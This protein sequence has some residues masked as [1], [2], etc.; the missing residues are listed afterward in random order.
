LV[1]AILASPLAFGSPAGATQLV[2]LDFDTETSGGEHFYLEAERDAIQ[3]RLEADYALF[4]Y[5][6]TQTAPS[7]GDFSTLFFNKGASGGLADAIDFRNLDPNDTASFNVNGWL[8]GAGQP[9]ATSDN[10]IA[11]SATVG[12]HVL[13]HIFGLRHGDS[14]GPIGS[15]IHDPPGT[16]NY[17]PDYPGPA[18]ATETTDHIMASG[19]SV[20]STLN[21]SVGNPFFSERSAVKL[22]FN[23]T[24]TVVAEQGST[25]GSISAAQPLGTLPSLFVPNTLQP[26]AENAG[27]DFNVEAIDITGSISTPGES[28]FYSFSGS[29]ND[30]INLEVMS[31][32]LDRIVDPF[33][34]LDPLVRV[35]DSGGDLVSYFGSPATNDDEFETFD[36]ILIDLVLPADDT[37]FIEVLDSPLTPGL[38]TGDYEL[39]F[40]TFEATPIPEP[41]TIVMFGIGIV[42][43][44]AFGQQRRPS[45]VAGGMNDDCT[46]A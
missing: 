17:L 6:F 19:A 42:G 14:F 23:E 9:A 41:S 31:Q 7:S 37:Y 10:I 33:D 13:G 22:A 35:F 44:I 45:R 25:H 11:A 20:G 39:F 27:L 34:P 28:D 18:G 15:G 12:A 43:L 29:A 2:F 26:G 30:L 3:G 21:D 38:D 5:A 16:V 4:D 1:I 36:S 32:A 40:W 46:K 8:G 24:G